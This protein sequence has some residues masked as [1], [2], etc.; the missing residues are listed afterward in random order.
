MSDKVFEGARDLVCP[1][2]LSLSLCLCLCLSLSL[3]LSLP[4]R[5]NLVPDV[6]GNTLVRVVHRSLRRDAV[7][8]P[9]G[10]VVRRELFGELLP[11]VEG[12]P[13]LQVVA[14]HEHG[15]PG[16]DGPEPLEQ[17]LREPGGVLLRERVEEVA[18]EEV[19]EH[20]DAR[21][22]E[23]EADD[24]RELPAGRAARLRVRP[25]G[26]GELE[27]V[28]VGVWLGSFFFFF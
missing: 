11:P 22:A 2:S 18:A 1:I 9:A 3:P 13:R 17:H 5:I 28:L 4:P 25:V 16:P 12:Q 19:E 6:R 20:R 23:R 8:G 7:E 26:L 10:Q 27:E 15:H 21:R 14:Q 24:G